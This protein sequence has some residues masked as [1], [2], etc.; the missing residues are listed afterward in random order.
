MYRIQNI[1]NNHVRLGL[2]EII[3]VI[4]LNHTGQSSIVCSRRCPIV[5][6]H[7]GLKFSSDREY[8]LV[9][10]CILLSLVLLVACPRASKL[11]VGMK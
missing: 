5:F 8:L 4:E 9:E 2:E 6:L 10:M 7:I 11:G 1:W 3:L